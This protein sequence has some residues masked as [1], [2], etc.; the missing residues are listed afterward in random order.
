MAGLW[1]GREPLVLASMSPARRALIEA[2]GLPVEVEAPGIDERAVEAPLRAAGMGGGAVAR[3]LAAAKA[4]AVAPQHEGRIIVAADQVLVCGREVLAK[5]PDREMARRQ[6]GR[7]AGRT[8]VLVSAAAVVV[9]GRIVAEFADEA[10]LTMRRLDA[11][12]I[13]RYLDLA[14]A[15]V[16][17]NVG[18][19]RIEGLGIH[20][21]DRI[22]G[23]HATILGLP[24]RML[25]G[26]LRRMDLIGL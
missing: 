8:H 13:D 5:P 6:L 2:A 22:E 24:L 18:A 3:R 4:M 1:R 23:E 19:Y 9:D 17:A 12:A 21:F 14:G 20:L 15:E 7:L 26:E 25:L 11:A 16:T 10:R